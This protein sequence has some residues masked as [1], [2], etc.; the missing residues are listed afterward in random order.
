MD[1]ISAV[2]KLS[3]GNKVR[4]KTWIK[5]LYILGHHFNFY[6]EDKLKEGHHLNIDC[7]EALDWEVVPEQN[8]SLYSKRDLANTFIDRSEVISVK[9]I[10]LKLKEFLKEYTELDNVPMK[11][12]FL[13]K[14]A[15][16]HFGKELLE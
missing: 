12:T 7:T 11:G 4:R 1:F 15:L 14:M 8:W 3:E 10:K 16:K 5:G 13:G 9:Q 6:Y 2:K